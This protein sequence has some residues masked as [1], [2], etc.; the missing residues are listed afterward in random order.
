VLLDYLRA[1]GYVP[2]K[3]SF[4]AGFSETYP[5]FVLRRAV[6]CFWQSDNLQAFCAMAVATLGCLL[7]LT[8]FGLL[9]VAVR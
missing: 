6:E 2:E 4:Q 5:A 9:A 7:A 1:E 3:A 8:A